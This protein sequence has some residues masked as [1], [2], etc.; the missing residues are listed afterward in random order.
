MLDRYSPG[1]VRTWSG[2]SSNCGNS[3]NKRKKFDEILQVKD[4]LSRQIVEE[5]ITK[6]DDVSQNEIKAFTGGC[7]FLLK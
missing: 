5:N 4:C 7:D 1:R 6:L 3:Y 2:S